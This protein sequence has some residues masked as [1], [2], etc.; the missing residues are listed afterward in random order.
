VI[1]GGSSLTVLFL[2]LVLRFCRTFPL[3]LGLDQCLLCLMLRLVSG[4]EGLERVAALFMHRGEVAFRILI[5][6]V[7]GTD[8]CGRLLIMPT[9]SGNRLL[10]GG[11]L[12]IHREGLRLHFIAAVIHSGRLRG[13]V[14]APLA[15]GPRFGLHRPPVLIHHALMLRDG[16]ALV[17]DRRNACVGEM[18]LLGDMV[19]LLI[20]MSGMLLQMLRLLICVLHLL[21]DMRQML[22]GL[23]GMP[24]HAFHEMLS[25]CCLLADVVCLLIRMTAE[26]F[27]MLRVLLRLLC[28]LV[29]MRQ[30]LI[31]LPRHAV[32][33]FN[34]L[35]RLTCKLVDLLHL[36][37]RVLNGLVDARGSFIRRC[38]ELC[39]MLLCTLDGIPCCTG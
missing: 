20:C 36:L 33:V 38:G 6:G 22:I 23:N 32:E 30:L 25:L 1:S 2:S 11:S 39:R 37:V 19:G 7:N 9:D 13:D 14:V 35:I 29:E 5:L 28:L 16:F 17:I 24:T 12:L 18:H 10:H 3:L 26:L 31:C 15:G 27:K 4:F 21:L 34:A 8:F